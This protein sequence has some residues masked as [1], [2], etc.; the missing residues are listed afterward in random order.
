MDRDAIRR[1]HDAAIELRA[2]CDS[3]CAF[4]TAGGA[5]GQVN[6]YTLTGARALKFL[7]ALDRE[8]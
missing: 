8:I 2:K 7:Y 4:N 5:I 1:V 6:C 3:F